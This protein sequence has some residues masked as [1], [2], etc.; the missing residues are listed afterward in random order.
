MHATSV[1]NT[2]QAI[3]ID[4]TVGSKRVA[5]L[6]DTGSTTSVFFRLRKTYTAIS[7]ERTKNR[8]PQ[9]DNSLWRPNG[10]AK[11]SGTASEITFSG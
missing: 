1:Q 4:I 10:E 3:N 11:N 6:I 8:Q 5:A 9:L 2:I 7:K